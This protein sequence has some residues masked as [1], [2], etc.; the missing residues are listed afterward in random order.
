MAIQAVLILSDAS[1]ITPMNFAFAFNL[2]C[3]RCYTLAT[4]YQFVSTTGSVRFTAEGNRR[5]AEIR[6]QLEAL[7]NA[8]LAIDEVQA[9]VN[10]LAG[11]LLDVMRTELISPRPAET[12]VTAPDEGGSV[13]P[14]TSAEPTASSND[15]GPPPPTEPQPIEQT[16]EVLAEQTADTTT[17]ETSGNDT[18]AGADS[19][20]SGTDSSQTSADTTSE[21]TVDTTSAPTTEPTVQAAE[22]STP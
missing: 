19:S 16:A 8:D 20:A 10:V 17:T 4:A 3:E 7:R 1:V 13:A 11:Q 5:I 21:T 6:R 14:A 2:D 22:T 18:T 15:A 12:G 9:R